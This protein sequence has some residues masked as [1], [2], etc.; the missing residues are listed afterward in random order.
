MRAATAP[1][2]IASKER[3]LA[4]VQAQKRGK[5]L[6]AR[7]HHGFFPRR[8]AHFA[9]RLVQNAD[10]VLAHRYSVGGKTSPAE[11][12]AN[13]GAAVVTDASPGLDDAQPHVEVF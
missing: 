2:V 3:A 8:Q 12:T 4:L 10:D 1:L 11:T 6:S 9:R 5:L 13:E 7:G